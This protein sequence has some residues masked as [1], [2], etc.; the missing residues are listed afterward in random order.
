M[1]VGFRTLQPTQKTAS[2]LSETAFDVLFRVRDRRGVWACLRVSIPAVQGIGAQS[3]SMLDSPG[4]IA[5]GV[6]VGVRTT[7]PT[8]CPIRRR[9][10]LETALGYYEWEAL[11]DELGAAGVS[12]AHASVDVEVVAPHADGDEVD[13]LAV[14][15]LMPS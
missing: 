12:S 9:S 13:H 1:H 7:P 3:W 8:G 14:G 6:R 15:V 5:V 11:P 10:G 4:F 2:D